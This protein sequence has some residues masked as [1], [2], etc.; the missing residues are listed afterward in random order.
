MF[1]SVQ[2]RFALRCVLFGIGGFL[3]SL[4]A[5]VYGSGLT[6]GEVIVALSSGW[7]VGL[8]YAGIGYKSNAVEPSINAG[9]K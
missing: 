3:S 9:D 6:L 8:M 7:G 1:K 4:A 5:S 2:S